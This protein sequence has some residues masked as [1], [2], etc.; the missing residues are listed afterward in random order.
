MDMT[1][2]HEVNEVEVL[3]GHL[4]PLKEILFAFVSAFT[5]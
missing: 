2:A 1:P 5:P 3:A 4:A